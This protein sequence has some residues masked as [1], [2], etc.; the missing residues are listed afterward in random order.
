MRG[1]LSSSPSFC[2]FPPAGEGC[3]VKGRP[4]EGSTL[5]GNCEGNVLS[6][7]ILPSVRGERKNEAEGLRSLGV[8]LVLFWFRPAVGSFFPFG[9]GSE[10]RYGSILIRSN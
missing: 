6:L 2:I 7:C 9:V 10:Q 8:L 1:V 4:D 3:E 5:F